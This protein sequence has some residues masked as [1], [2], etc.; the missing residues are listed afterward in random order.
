MNN[1][2]DKREWII[3]I[4]SGEK[5][6]LIL[7]R[8]D[9][10]SIYYNEWEKNLKPLLN[11]YKFLILDIPEKLAQEG[12]NIEY[13]VKDLACE[14]HKFLIN[15]NLKISMI[16]GLSLGG[17]IAQELSILKDME[18]IPLMLIS[19]N[20]FA[21]IKLKGVFSTWS[22][23]TQRFGTEGF[24]LGLLPWILNSEELPFMTL[25]NREYNEGD[26]KIQIDKLKSS[27]KAV[28]THDARETSKKI[29]APVV[30]LFGK[31]SVLLGT[32][33]GNEFNQN[34]KWC[35]I[36]N[37]ENAGMRVLDENYDC[38]ISI[39]KDFINKNLK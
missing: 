39:I 4:G 6:I 16:F 7:P 11:D 20:L 37:I 34:I 12:S 23:L 21:S 30:A 26:S 13:T 35:E 2:L 1:S 38:T 3:E 22:L 19:T 32:C 9:Y 18:N 28:A 36:F 5:L 24:D 8:M 15:N 25:P 10:N 31:N 27:L 17:M 29:V 14:V 33:E